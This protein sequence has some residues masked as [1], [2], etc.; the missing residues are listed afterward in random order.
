MSVH[1]L[2][3]PIHLTKRRS[4]EVFSAGFSH[5]WITGVAIVVRRELRLAQIDHDAALRQQ[6]IDPA[7]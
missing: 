1:C 7:L 2:L 5:R 4:A 6:M 3:H